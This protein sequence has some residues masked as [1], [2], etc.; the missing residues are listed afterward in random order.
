MKLSIIAAALII[1][2]CTPGSA[3]TS[4]RKPVPE[5]AARDSLALVMAETGDSAAFAT[6]IETTCTGG[7]K[8][9][10]FESMLSAPASK[11]LVKVAMGA[12]NKLGSDPE[13]KRNGHVYAH[14]IG[15]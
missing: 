5:G 6:L 7:E 3:I 15:I 4:S 9:S 8:A 11:G 2:G 13:I 12:L 10:C 1:C 14:A